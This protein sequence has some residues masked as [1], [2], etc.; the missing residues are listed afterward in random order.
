MIADLEIDRI[1]AEN[2][3]RRSL[4][5]SMLP[6]RRTGYTRTRLMACDGFEVLALLWFPGAATPI[7]DHGDSYCATRIL[8][9]ELE[10]ARY[11][12]VGPEGVS[13]ALRLVERGIQ[14][15]GEGDALANARELHSVKNVGSVNALSLH[16]YAPRYTEYGVYDES[17]A[18][19][20]RAFSRYDAILDL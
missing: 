18:V 13:G 8:A 7:H 16:I 17:G 2:L 14:R 19:I 12:R 3:A 9:G 20:A 4:W 11:H 6:R 10:V 1:V 5:E 15:V